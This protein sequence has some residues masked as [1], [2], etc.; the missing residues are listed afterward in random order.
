[1]NLGSVADKARTIFKKRG[2]SEAA[3]ADFDELRN[4]AGKN[5]S[6]ADKAKD[7]AE[8]LKDP[9]APTPPSRP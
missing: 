7:A 5:E 9:G 2:G 6:L 8:A 3:K 1:V 4:I